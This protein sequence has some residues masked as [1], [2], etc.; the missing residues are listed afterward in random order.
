MYIGGYFQVF[1][2]DPLCWLVRRGMIMVGW[3]FGC[4]YKCIV[5]DWMVECIMYIGGYC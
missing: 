4:F 1:G 2:L 3:F 5:G